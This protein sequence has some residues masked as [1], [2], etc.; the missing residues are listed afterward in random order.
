MA[1][2]TYVVE[3]VYNGEG[4]YWGQWT[5]PVQLALCTFE[6][7]APEVSTQIRVHAVPAV[8][9]WNPIGAL[10]GYTCSVC[11]H[12]EEVPQKLAEPHLCPSCGAYLRGGDVELP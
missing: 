4:Y 8:G 5:D 1:R 2:V 9:T 10:P 11:R 7:R 3:R 12:L 6:M